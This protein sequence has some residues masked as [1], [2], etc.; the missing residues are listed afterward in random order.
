MAEKLAN[1]EDA[2]PIT[3]E[4][5]FR[6]KD[7]TLLDVE[8]TAFVA[9]GRQARRLSISAFKDVTGLKRAEQEK[10]R[11]QATLES[12]IN[13]VSDLIFYKDREG[14]YIGCNT[15]YASARRKTRPR[16]CRPDLPRPVR[17]GHRRRAWTKRDQAVMTLTC[18]SIRES[19][20]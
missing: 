13:S 4:R 8:V 17:P 12:L 3:F 18:A 10:K 11:Q 14:R 19:S 9:T 2:T 7:G 16:D 5:V 6:R 15:A 20:G 1:T